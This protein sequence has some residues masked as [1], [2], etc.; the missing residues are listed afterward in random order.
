MT[1]RHPLVGASLAAL[2]VACA[3]LGLRALPADAA[4]AQS[5]RVVTI[6]TVPPLAGVTVQLDG[7]EAATDDEGIATVSTTNIDDTASRLVVV[8]SQVPLPTGDGHYQLSRV[9]GESLDLVLGYDMYREVS[10]RFQ[11]LQGRALTYDEIDSLQLKNTLGGHYD[12]VD[13]S[14]PVLLHANRAVS[15]PTGPI[16]R[17]IVWSVDS[18]MVGTSNVINRSE[19]RFTPT[20]QTDVLITTLFFDAEII[21]TDLFFGGPVEGTV[22]LEDPAG[23]VTEHPVVDGKVHLEDLPRGDYTV[24][25]IGKGLKMS[26]P[27][28]L[29]RDQTVDLALLSYKDLALVGVGL[30]IFVTGTF[31]IGLRRRA[32]RRRHRAAAPR[33]SVMEAHT[34]QLHEI[35]RQAPPPTPSRLAAGVGGLI[36]YLREIDNAAVRLSGEAVKPPASEKP[37]RPREPAP[38]RSLRY[39]ALVPASPP[40]DDATDRPSPVEP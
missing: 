14:A 28:A 30:A 25:M 13:R 19:V 23:L 35:G 2:V 22:L 37:A 9:F 18:V 29:S 7:K 21:V 40:D 1:G 26:R 10:F 33:L 15:S 27:V 36:N 24:T 12:N 39:S 3:V 32:R 16:I 20:T 5:A 17:D 11:T 8:D 6:H 34:P 38:P 4:P 31:V